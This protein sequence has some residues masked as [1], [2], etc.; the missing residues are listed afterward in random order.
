MQ[1]QGSISIM[2]RSCRALVWTIVWAIAPWII[3]MPAWSADPFRSGTQARP[4][5]AQTEAVFEAL[6]RD[7]HYRKGKDLLPAALQ[8]DRREPLTLT[9]AAGIA[10]LDQDWEAYRRFSEQTLRTAQ[11][12]GTEDPLRSNLY[13][14]VGHFLLAAYEISEAGAGP[15]LG[16]SAALLRVQQMFRFLDQAEAIDANDPELNLIRGYIEW[17]IANNIGFFDSEAALRRLTNRAAPAYLSY[18][19]TA[20]V[21]RDS[22]QLPL[23]LE[24]VDRA[25]GNAPNNPELLY[26][27]AQIL[28][29]LGNYQNSRSYLDRALAQQDQLPREIVQEML[30]ARQE[31]DA[32]VERQ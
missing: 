31:I 7:G 10:Y 25:I 15:F 6:F 11:N 1:R 4:I 13:Q 16:A 12:L 14:A 20:L 26:L 19:G 18:R 2:T 8:R 27:K 22:N 30:T 9:L 32:I 23:A 17:G 29:M 5:S 3:A 21:Y 28:R 24:A